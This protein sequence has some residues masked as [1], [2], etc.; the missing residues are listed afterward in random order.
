MNNYKPIRPSFFSP[1]SPT[2]EIME[3]SQEEIEQAS[4][5]EKR[6][7]SN[8]HSI[9]DQLYFVTRSRLKAN[10]N[11][12]KIAVANILLGI[13]TIYTRVKKTSAVTS[14]SKL[15]EDQKKEE[16][17]SS[18]L[19]IPEES[20]KKDSF[21]LGSSEA[22]DKEL[23]KIIDSSFLNGKL[24]SQEFLDRIVDLMASRISIEKNTKEFMAFLDKYAK[25]IEK[26]F[27]DHDFKIHGKGSLITLDDEEEKADG[28]IILTSFL[29]DEPQKHPFGILKRKNSDDSIFSLSKFFSSKIPQLTIHRF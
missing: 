20:K 10:E 1:S 4:V 8:N 27:Y 18:Q 9:D 14:H 22:Q 28:R 3:S 25:I 15:S 17:I 23:N 5:D 16:D 21:D 24:K 7:T 26:K 12:L 29:G 11:N 6:I 2:G 19:A 13:L